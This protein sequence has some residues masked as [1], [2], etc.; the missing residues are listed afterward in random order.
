MTYTKVKAGPAAVL[1]LL[2]A[3]GS[4]AAVGCATEQ[5]LVRAPHYTLSH[6]D[7]WKVKSVATRDGEP[8]EIS[9]GRYSNTVMSEGVG[10]DESTPYEAQQ[11]DVDVRIYTWP[12]AGNGPPALEVVNKLAADPKLELTQHGRIS[13]DRGECGETFQRK[14]KV[15]GA[16]EEAL[17]LVKQ[18]GFRTIVVGARHAPVLLGIVARVPYE[19]DGG[20]YCHNLKNMQLQLD[21]LLGGLKADESAAPA[22]APA[23][24]SA[25]PASPPAAAAPAAPAPAAPAAGGA[26]AS[27][28]APAPAPPA[29]P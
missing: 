22:P 12:D 27:S 13:A 2:F 26:A 9:I 3:I 29:P 19:V 10:A 16:S 5:K 24:A 15:L 28:A 8:T 11:A 4:L 21:L 6:P 1:P 7:Y 18:P 20:Q 25:P 14:Y 23:P 17:D